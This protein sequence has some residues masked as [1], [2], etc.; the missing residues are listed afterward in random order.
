MVETIYT[1]DATTTVWQGVTKSWLQNDEYPKAEAIVVNDGDILPDGDIAQSLTGGKCIRLMCGHNPDGTRGGYSFYAPLYSSTPWNLIGN[2]KVTI[3]VYLNKA[4]AAIAFSV[5]TTPWAVTELLVYPAGNIP[6]KTW[7]NIT[8]DLREMA[9]LTNIAGFQIKA[10]GIG[11]PA[12][13]ETYYVLTDEWTIE[14][15]TGVPTLRAT[16]DP[17]RA[18]AQ[19][20]TALLLTCAP[21]GGNLPF[22]I[23]WFVNGESVKIDSGIQST[24]NFNC[25]AI[26]TY[27]IHTIVSDTPIPAQEYT[28][29]IVESEH[30]IVMVNP[31]PPPIIPCRPLH[32]SGNKILTDQNIDIH[33]HGVN[34]HGFE[35]NANGH[36]IDVNGNYYYG[37]NMT[38]QSIL[39]AQ[40]IEQHLDGVRSWGA[41]HIR[42][43]QSLGLLLDRTT[44]TIEHMKT[45]CNKAKERGLYVI[46]DG[47]SVAWFGQSGYQQDEF[48]YPPYTTRSDIIP[49]EQA[50]IDFWRMMGRE[51]KDFNNVIFELWNEVGHHNSDDVAIREHWF[52]VCNS[53]IQAIRNEG[54]SNLVVLGW[55]WGTYANLTAPA[56]VSSGRKF[57]WVFDPLALGKVNDPLG[58]IVVTQHLYRSDGHLGIKLYDGGG[59]AYTKED[60][61]AVLRYTRN[62]EVAEQY[63]LLIGETGASITASDLENELIGVANE[64]WLFTHNVEAVK[65]HY[66]GFWF[67]W[68]GPFAEVAVGIPNYAP[69]SGGAVLLTDMIR[70]QSEEILPTPISPIIPVLVAVGILVLVAT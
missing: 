46:I 57:D 64:L 25:D 48:P 24:L 16:I 36:W 8:L 27:E 42:M 54:C 51:F 7:V 31:A 55:A 10:D 6:S 18:S 61:D 3:P 14:P 43:H 56:T 4:T 34:V 52:D 41:N 58:N 50:F 47:Y 22:N 62:Y 68:E 35:D 39:D 67:W 32:V 29:Q 69:T 9:S 12:S 20:N 2:E 60:I 17:L 49:D 19:I 21:T 66:T 63:P 53:C 38:W 15:A 11:G 59:H 65:I 23:E 5:I 70:L 30:A 44:G 26:G 13:A 45:V 33:L 28:G 40:L 1:C 37:Q